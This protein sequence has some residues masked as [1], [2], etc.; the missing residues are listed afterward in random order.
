MNRSQW[1]PL[2][3]ALLLANIAQAGVYIESVQRSGGKGGAEQTSFT[4]QIQDGNAR[5][6]SGGESHSTM[7][8]KDDVMYILDASRKSYMAMD[9]ASMESTAGAMNDMMTQMRAQMANLPPEQRAAMENMMKQNGMSMP[10]APAK[11]PVYDATP[12]GANE[13]AAGRS[14][15]VWNVKR[16]GVLWQQLCVVP[17]AGLPGKDELQTLSKKMRV[18]VEKMGNMAQQF[19]G[20]PAQQ[21]EALAAKINGVPFITRRYRDGVLESKETAVKAWRSQAINASTFEIPAN[22]TKQEMPNLRRP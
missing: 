17:Y 22:Y 18:L 1:L 20:N 6:D 3:T 15:A 9:R 12:T 13:K 21:D 8:F 2:A 10:G 4:M 11:Q 16:D 7:I 5:I 14:C 19:A